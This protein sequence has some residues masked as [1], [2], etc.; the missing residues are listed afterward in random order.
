[1]NF[2]HKICL[3]EPEVKTNQWNVKV[4]DLSCGET[5]V[6]LKSKCKQTQWSVKMLARFIT[7]F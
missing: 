4:I 7:K 3:P 2:W 1:M 6:D 5:L